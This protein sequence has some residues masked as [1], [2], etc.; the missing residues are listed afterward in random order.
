M[1]KLI[2]FNNISLDGYF[3]D[4][5]GDMSWAH[6]RKKDP[7]WDA[8]VRG[9]ASGGGQLLFGRITYEL[10]ASFWPTPQAAAQY[11]LVAKSMNAM[12]KTIFSR[13]LKEATWSNTRLIKRGLTAEVL[14]MKNAPRGKSIAIFGS[15]TIVTQLAAENLI[16]EY[17]FVIIPI[18]LGGGRTLFEGIKTPPAL[19]LTST[20][21]FKNGN[22][23]VTYKPV[24]KK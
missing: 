22:V 5:R 11:P 3:T 1:N 18:I 13:T 23:F 4:A 7:E 9:N 10:M 6:Q 8:F 19:K 12:P 15:G 21:S 2:V 16:D 14:K 20:R 24:A 17:Q